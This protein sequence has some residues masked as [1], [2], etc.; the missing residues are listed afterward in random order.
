[1]ILKQ[2]TTWTAATVADMHKLRVRKFYNQ[3]GLDAILSLTISLY[4]SNSVIINS[5]YMQG[6]N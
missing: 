2:W 1:M 6:L 3:P 4:Q 5:F